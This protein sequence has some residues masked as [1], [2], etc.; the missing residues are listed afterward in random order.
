MEQQAK[1]IMAA[2]NTKRVN[3]PSLM[4]P[5]EGG[6]MTGMV[7]NI[8]GNAMNEDDDDDDDD[9]DAPILPARKSGGK[10]SK[11][12]KADKSSGGAGGG[13]GKMSSKKIKRKE[14]QLEKKV[15][16]AEMLALS[17]GAMPDKP[18]RP[19]SAYNLFFQLGTSQMIENLLDFFSDTSS[20][21]NLH[22]LI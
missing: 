12:A 6:M 11:N 19:F 10:K 5:T 3:L 18:K 13:E 22:S 17:A 20:L 4:S 8:I 16:N 9:D 14:K 7:N 15:K 2:E 21:A 1:M